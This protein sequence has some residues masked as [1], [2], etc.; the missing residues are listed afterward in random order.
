MPEHYVPR[1]ADDELARR[2]AV[3]GAVAIDGPKACGKTMTASRVAKTVHRFLTDTNL[4][5][6]ARAAPGALFAEPTPILFDEWQ[7]VPELWNHVK[8]AADAA[9]PRK[10]QYLLT[11][12]ATPDDDIDRHSGTGRISTLRMRPMSLYETGH[13]T[14]AVAL[15]DLF[16]G[17]LKPTANLAMTVPEIL[18]RIVIGGWPALLDVSVPDAQQWLQDYLQ[19]IVEQDLPRLGPNRDPAKVRRLLTALA[20]GTANPIKISTLAADVGG[21][22]GPVS[23]DT[24]QAYLTGLERLMLTEDVPAWAPHMR[25][26]TPLRK[27]ATRYMVDPSLGLAALGQGPK[28]LL[29]DLNAAGF[30]FES[31]VVRDLRIYS[32]SLRGRLAHWRDKNGHEVD[33]ILTLGDGRWAALEVKLSPEKTSE[34]AASLIRFKAKVDTSKI[35]EPE[36]MAVITATGPAHVRPDG[37]MVVPITTLGP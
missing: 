21:A 1:I 11:G 29:H 25:S 34:A 27:D 22:D 37:V 18:E 2:L 6:I 35:G 30:H 13:S 5:A 19:T 14:G 15:T 24:I 10:G 23:W 33:V 17:N 32:Q 28:Q 31:L 8:E 20:R 26:T 9:H 7:T 36:F 12:S 16:D 3:S 4:R